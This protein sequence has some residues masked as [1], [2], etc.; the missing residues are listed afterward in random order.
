MADEH[1]GAGLRCCRLAMSADGRHIA[2]VG[3]D[4][5]GSKILVQTLDAGG[6]V[7]AVANSNGRSARYLGER[8]VAAACGRDRTGQ[9]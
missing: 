6:S 4:E 1:S 9:R 8:Y 3:G 5:L 7:E 2:Y